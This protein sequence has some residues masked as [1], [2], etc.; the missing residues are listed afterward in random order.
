[1]EG[2]NLE[3]SFTLIEVLVGIFLIM[4]VF[5]GIFG[6]YQLSL[7]VIGLS[8]TKIIATAIANGQIE[9]IRNLAY[10]SIGVK[11]SFPDGVLEAVTTTIQN[12]FNIRLKLE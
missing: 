5:L 10:G 6:A 3:R 8:K 2:K 12:K 1:M 11:G 7:K 4:I 9:K